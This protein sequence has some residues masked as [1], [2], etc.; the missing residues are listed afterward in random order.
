MVRQ[1]RLHNSLEQP[2]N[3]PTYTH[4]SVCLTVRLRF[5]TSD[6]WNVFENLMFLSYCFLFVFV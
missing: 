1:R 4:L 3:K 6:A 2:V 5:S